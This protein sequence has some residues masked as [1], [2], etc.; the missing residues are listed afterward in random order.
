VVVVTLN[1]P[2]TPTTHLGTTCSSFTSVSLT[3]PI[4][5]FCVRTPSRTSH[6]LTTHPTGDFAV[7]ILSKHQTAASLAFSSPRTQHDLSAFP[8]HIDACT[9]L[10]IL[11]NCLG[12]LICRVCKDKRVQVGDHEVWFGEV[13]RIVPGVGSV[14]GETSMEPLV[15]YESSYRSVGD[16]VFMERLEKGG[17]SFREWT[18]RAHL[19]MAWIYLRESTKKEDAFPKIKKAIQTHNAANAHLIKHGYNETITWFYLHL[20]DLAL[21]DH[22]LHSSA[23]ASSSSSITPA[24][25]QNEDFLDFIARYP[26]LEDRRV[27]GRYYSAD[28]LRSE[29]ARER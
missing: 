23:S 15:Y 10:P 22:H 13:V 4:I 7:H 9:S 25:N 14:S 26:V 28:V 27:V 20:I 19:R 17:L 21:K 12:V 5:S 11:H 2:S 18:H 24:V 8:H 1:T 3:P 29:G 6:V 16:E